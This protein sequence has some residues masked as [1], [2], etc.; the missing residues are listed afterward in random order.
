M[1]VPF[2]RSSAPEKIYK[3][4]YFKNKKENEGLL[5]PHIHLIVEIS[6]ILRNYQRIYV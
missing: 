1:L 2:D 3:K 4:P 5:Q 6:I